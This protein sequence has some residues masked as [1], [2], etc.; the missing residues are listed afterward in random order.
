MRLWGNNRGRGKVGQAGVQ[1]SDGSWAGAWKK[2]GDRDWW[3]RRRIMGAERGGEWRRW[4][5]GGWECGEGRSGA[6]KEWARAH[7]SLPQ[8]SRGG[9]QSGCA[10]GQV[11]VRG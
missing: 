9:V 3:G 2:N 1:V 6:G 11:G 4:I 8:S 5:Q 10:R 7:P